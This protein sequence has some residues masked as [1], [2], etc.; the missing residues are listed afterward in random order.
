MILSLPGILTPDE[1]AAI[2]ALCMDGD[3]VDGKFSARGAARTVKNN[4]QMDPA[5]ERFKDIETQIYQ[6]ASRSSR[7]QAMALPSR[8]HS[9]RVSKYTPGMQY[10]THVDNAVMG[11]GRL[12]TD[13]SVTVFLSEPSD[14]QG[15]DLQIGSPY[16]ESFKLAAGSLLAYP[17][18][19]L[20]RVMPVFSGERLV[21]VFWVK[22]QVRDAAQRQILADL[23]AVKR[24]MFERQGQTGEFDLLN[25]SYTNLLRMWAE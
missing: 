21:V 12:R 24:T 20:H 2:K 25:S 10:G 7:F 11:A 22:S 8:L 16:D 23:D 17:A 15:G 9:M 4:L 5:S 18:T 14:Y 19:T 6:A 3:F 1:L 13:V